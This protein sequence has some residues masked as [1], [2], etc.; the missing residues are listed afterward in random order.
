MTVVMI[1]A[2]FNGDNSHK[3]MA[4]V[5]ES[6][7]DI[8]EKWV[9]TMLDKLD[10]LVKKGEYE[11]WQIMRWTVDD[12]EFDDEFDPDLPDEEEDDV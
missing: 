2:Y 9:V 5:E 7:W 8:E 3:L 1:W 11:K 4:A 6:K 10:R 12:D